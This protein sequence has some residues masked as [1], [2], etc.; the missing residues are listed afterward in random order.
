MSEL[1]T[2]TTIAGSIPAYLALPAK[3]PAPAVLMVPSIFGVDADIKSFADRYAERGL[4]AVAFDPFWRTDGGVLT[5]SNSDQAARAQ[6]RNKSFAFED[7]VTDMAAIVAHLRTMREYN[8]KFAVAGYCFG[9]RYAFLAAS[10]LH[11]D[12]AISFHGANIGYH[13]DEAPQVTCPVSFHFG[14]DDH[15]IPMDEV[16]AIRAAL[17]GNAQAEIFDYDGVGHSFT[18]VSRPAVFNAGAASLSDQRSM[19]TLA[20]LQ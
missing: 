14:G 16:N 17:A 6:A 13:L 4:I 11:A 12:A 19:Q 7:G 2:S 15:V 3:T 20:R 9:G 10:R 1:G 8:G 5:P 18:A